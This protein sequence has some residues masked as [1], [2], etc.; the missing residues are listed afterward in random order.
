M[1]LPFPRWILKTPV[2]VYQTELSEDGEPVEELIFDGLACYEDK[3]RQVMDAKR[4]LVQV[5]GKLIFEGD[6]NPDKMIEG[7]VRIG[8]DRK[9]INRAARPR[10]PDGSVFST[11]LELS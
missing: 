11:E 3:S 9:T 7:Y 2:Q 5:S 1:K 8:P 6:I 10:N 4:Q